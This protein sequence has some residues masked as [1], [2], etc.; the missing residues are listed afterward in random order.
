MTLKIDGN[1]ISNAS[2]ANKSHSPLQTNIERLSSGK[3]INS[4]KDDAARLAI[5]TRFLSQIS[6]SQQAYRNV[7]DG[8]SM[9]QTAE[10]SVQEISGNVQRIRELAVQSANGGLS[11]T[12]RAS[13]QAEAAGL[14]EEIA[15]ATGNTQFNGVPLLDNN[16]SFEFQVGANGG[17]TVSFNT[18]DVASQI[19]AQGFNTVDIS[20]AAG[21]SSA[22]SVADNVLDTLNQARADYGASINRFESAGRNLLNLE[23]NLEASRSRLEDADYAR[24]TADLTRNMILQRAE[25]AMQGQANVAQQHVLQLLGR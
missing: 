17:E 19:N 25:N 22:I 9:A 2:R 15:R 11:D 18:I 20:T 23:E 3:R 4:A 8:I 10:A 1:P 16:N 7:N 14:Q 5:A 21:A 13:L 24:E 12:D 6:G